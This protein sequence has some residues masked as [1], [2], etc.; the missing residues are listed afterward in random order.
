M[1]RISLSPDNLRKAIKTAIKL[2]AGRAK[3]MILGKRKRIIFIT[4][5]GETPWFM[6]HS[7]MVTILAANTI[8]MNTR[9]LVKKVGQI[10]L[11]MYLYRVFIIG[12]IQGVKDPRIRVTTD[13][14]FD[15]IYRMTGYFFPPDVAKAMP[16]RQTYTN[17]RRRF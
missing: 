2:A 9:R 8:N 6:T 11:N 17:R 14:L 15:R 7:E 12:R 5:R 3:R 13:E 10:S 16:D 4:I 1:A